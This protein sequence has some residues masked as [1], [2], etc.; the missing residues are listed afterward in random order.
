[1]LNNFPR[2]ESAGYLAVGLVGLQLL[3][4][5]IFPSIELPQWL[6]LS[7]VSILFLWGFTNRRRL[8]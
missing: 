1:M 7:L 2:L 5:V 4:R 8:C 6:L 3:T